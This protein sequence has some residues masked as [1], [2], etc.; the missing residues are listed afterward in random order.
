MMTPQIMQP[1]SGIAAVSTTLP[2]MQGARSLAEVAIAVPNASNAPRCATGVSSLT[3]VWL[4]TL[5]CPPLQSGPAR[6]VARA[7][8]TLD[9]RSASFLARLAVNWRQFIAIALN[10]GQISR[11]VGDYK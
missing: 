4:I 8:K 2:M 7:A 1:A 11:N 6:R 5:R 9:Q 10:F 3:T